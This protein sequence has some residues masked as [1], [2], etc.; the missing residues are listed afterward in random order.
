V[1]DLV[2][3]FRARNF[4]YAL[5]EGRIEIPVFFH[6]IHNGREGRLQTAEVQSQIVVLNRVF[7]PLG[8]DF[9]LA[10]IDYTDNRAWFRM[11]QASMEEENAKKKLG[12][13]TDQA[14][15]LYSCLPPGY[16]GWATLPVWLKDYPT[17]DGVVIAYTSL[18]RG[19]AP[20]DQGLT[21]VHEVGHW[22][23]LEHTFNGWDEKKAPAGGCV[24]PGD[25]VDDTPYEASP[26]FG[27]GIDLPC[28]ALGSRDTCPASPEADPITNYMDY[29]DDRCMSVFTPGQVAWMKEQTALYRPL[30][31][32]KATGEIRTFVPPK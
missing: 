1:L 29:P 27:P 23:G 24:P 20:F 14:L 6:V 15:N 5:K 9:T 18:P 12:K 17:D 22:L 7:Q 25:S 16:L 32:K 28:P 4:G 8:F 3:R 19:R 21:G 13:T 2:S 26:A 30:L 11:G 31:L 10:A